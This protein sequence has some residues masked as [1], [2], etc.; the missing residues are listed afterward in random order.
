MI[1][2]LVLMITLCTVAYSSLQAGGFVG[3]RPRA[4]RLYT[5][6]SPQEQQIA[7]P[8]VQAAEVEVREVAQDDLPIG[9]KFCLPG[10]YCFEEETAR[11]VSQLERCDE[12]GQATLTG[13]CIEDPEPPTVEEE[14][15][16]EE[17]YLNPDKAV[18]YTKQRFS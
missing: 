8:N 17:V 12:P 3:Q 18:Q 16:L 14:I 9:R 6:P 10:D 1:M 2:R 11:Q 5:R 13:A 15:T 4:H 7:E